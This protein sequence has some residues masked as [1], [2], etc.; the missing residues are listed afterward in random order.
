MSTADQDPSRAELIAL[1]EERARLLRPGEESINRALRRCVRHDLRVQKRSTGR[2]SASSTPSGGVPFTEDTEPAD[3]TDPEPGDSQAGPV[4]APGD[5]TEPDQEPIATAVAKARTVS[6][7]Q[8]VPSAPPAAVVTGEGGE[9]RPTTRRTR[10]RLEPGRVLGGYRIE[11]LLGTGG[12]GQVYRATQLSMNRQV[13]LKVLSPRYTENTRFRE[14]FLREAR[15][16]GRLQHPNLIAVHDVGEAEGL[17]FFSMELVEGR[18]AREELGDLPDSRFPDERVFAV[19]EQALE[20]L[21]Y[22]HG[23]GIIH[24]DVKPDNLMLMA[25]GTV[26]L[27]D[28][29]L[30]RCDNE[31]ADVEDF[32]TKTG[33]MM[34]TPYYMPPEQGRDAHRADQR[35][36]LYSLGA[37]LYHLACGHVPFEG[38]TAVAILINASTQSL[39]FPE[40]GPGEPLKRVIT[41]LMAKHPEDRPAS[42]GEA[43][44]MVRRLQAGQAVRGTQ[45]YRPQASEP[46]ATA[47]GTATS[48]RGAVPAANKGRWWWKLLLG[49]IALAAIAAGVVFA[50]YFDPGSAIRRQ[51]RDLTAHHR[52]AAAVSEIDLAVEREVRGA[53]KLAPL[54]ESVISEWDVWARAQAASAFAGIEAMIGG[55]KFDEALDAIGSIGKEEAWRS[56]G[57]LRELER[58]ESLLGDSALSKGPL[59]E[60]RRY[61]GEIV[62]RWL[63]AAFGSKVPV[64]DGRIVLRDDGDQILPSP[65]WRGR[66]LPIG[67]T[68]SLTA[69]PGQW[70]ELRAGETRVRLSDTSIE[71]TRGTKPARKHE[72][73]SDGSARFTIRRRQEGAIVE[74]G[75]DVY[76]LGE[77]EPRIVWHA[78]SGE[79][80][81]TATLVSPLKGGERS[82]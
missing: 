60:R 33:T 17:L 52:F 31:D 61:A 73:N 78:G 34:G 68:L 19:A 6:E 59:D 74:V 70:L 77:A 2:T 54:R 43:L 67:V 32:T 45:R 47:R 49:L 18:T 23:H 11:G 8:P 48:A 29:G 50:D 4:A 28:L 5:V 69:E 24:R 15:S 10:K 56:P 22:A 30:S 41:S 25:N 3:F 36:D 46:I 14:R 38:E 40:P 13:A 9:G 65:Q 81:V 75:P 82:R 76:P 39:E 12:M 58:L 57:M 79:L 44:E 64:Q 63:S 80:A 62:D 16:A 55:R 27:A 66:S 35:A 26:K 21:R 7:D 1:L 71:A 20:A 72:L 51:V 53:E 37:S 42:A